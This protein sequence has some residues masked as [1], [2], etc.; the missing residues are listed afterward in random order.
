MVSRLIDE[1]GFGWAM[2]IS[3]FL[4]LALLTFANLTIRSRITPHAKPLSL[5]DFTNPFKEPAFVLAVIGNFLFGF[6]V[7]I[8]VTYIVVQ[9]TADGMGQNLAQYLVPLINAGR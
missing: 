8:P 4:I 2:R 3:A 9:A 5:G 7:F 6:G 1:V